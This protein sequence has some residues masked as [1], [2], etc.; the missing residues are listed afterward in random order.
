V[1]RHV[2]P[3]TGVSMSLYYMYMFSPW[4]CSTKLLILR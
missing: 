2:Y 3:R 4:Y 1:E